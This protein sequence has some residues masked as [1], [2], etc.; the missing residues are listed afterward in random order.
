[1][2][3]LEVQDLKIRYEPK[4]HAALD[5]VTNITFSIEPGEFVGLILSLI[6]I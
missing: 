6:H 1:M 2:P 5:A 4:R 3:L